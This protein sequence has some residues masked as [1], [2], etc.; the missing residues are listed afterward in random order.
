MDEGSQRDVKSLNSIRRRDGG[1]QAYDREYIA[2]A[3][4]AGDS[5]G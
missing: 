5:R 4:M 2:S 1:V 3:E